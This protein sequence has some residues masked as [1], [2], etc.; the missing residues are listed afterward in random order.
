MSD[1][2]GLPFY[3][4]KDYAESMNDEHAQRPLSSGLHLVA[5]PIGNLGDITLRAIETLR[6]AR[7]VACEDT[8]M[9]GKL[10]E[11]LGIGKKKM[12]SYND[13]NADRKRDSIL[14]ILEAGETLALVSDA[15][16]PLI[17][18][19][20]Y[21]LVRACIE[22][23]IPVTSVP[24]PCAPVTALQ[25]SGLP[26]DR[27]VFLG[28]PPTRAAA[29]RSVLR[30]WKET[31]A[32]LVFFETGPRL[33]KSL[34][35]MIEVFGSDRP[36]ALARELTKKF[37]EIRRGSLQDIFDLCEQAPPRGELVLM[38]GGKSDSE[39]EADD[40]AT[41]ILLRQALKTM[42]VRDAASHVAQKTGHP[43]KDIYA[44]AVGLSKESRNA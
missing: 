43:R 27:F 42:S 7:L 12:I 22:Q 5:T 14:K 33:L 39:E 38:L 34:Q 25:L 24:G 32:T 31:T 19:P 8:R 29:R 11:R 2:H 13:H 16:T 26:T 10:F 20:G 37:E 18:D 36:A 44:Q 35:D 21:K 30:E 9:T 1:R 15:G 28:F 4:I 40:D 41:E 3:H 23:G 17:S 6:Q